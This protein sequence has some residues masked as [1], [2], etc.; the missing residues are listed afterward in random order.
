M[1]KHLGVSGD[2]LARRMHVRMVELV[3]AWMERHLFFHL[4]S[5]DCR[6]WDRTKVLERTCSYFF[7]VDVFAEADV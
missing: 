3:G 1:I 6:F 4:F 5:C 7:T 2:Q